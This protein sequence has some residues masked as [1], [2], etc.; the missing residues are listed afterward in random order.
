MS[1]GRK[2]CNERGERETDRERER[3]RGRD[4]VDFQFTVGSHAAFGLLGRWKYPRKAGWTSSGCGLF[5]ACSTQKEHRRTTL[6]DT[7]EHMGR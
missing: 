5:P 3:E 4:T 7:M 6:T 2:Y 1:R